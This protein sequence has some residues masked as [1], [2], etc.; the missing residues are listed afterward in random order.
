M[1]SVRIRSFSMASLL[2]LS[3]AAA[4]QAEV[5]AESSPVEELVV[6]AQKREQ[7]TIDVPIALTAYSGTFLDAL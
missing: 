2:V 4:A 1:L 5:S 6:T 7:K 3:A